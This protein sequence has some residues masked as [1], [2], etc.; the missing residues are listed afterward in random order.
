MPV[1][2]RYSSEQV[3]DILS[4]SKS[5]IQKWEKNKT[6][7]PNIDTETGNRFYDKNHLIPFKQA[8]EMLNSKWDDEIQ[9][10][11]LKEFT[12]LELFAGAGGLALG[13]EQAGFKAQM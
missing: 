6:L 5:I 4:V 3:A 10:K 1:N 7:I 11:P 8:H 12:C 13:L 9:T 2:A